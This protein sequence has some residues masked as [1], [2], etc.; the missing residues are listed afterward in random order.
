MYV[1]ILLLQ[2]LGSGVFLFFTY[3][4]SVPSLIQLY[5]ILQML[6]HNNLRL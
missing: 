5:S 1:D 6:Y 3:A 4:F 2:A